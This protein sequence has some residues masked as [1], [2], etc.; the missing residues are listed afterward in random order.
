[1]AVRELTDAADLDRVQVL[2][3]SSG[4]VRMPAGTMIRNAA[5]QQFASSY[6][7]TELL[8]S[9]WAPDE[10]QTFTIRFTPDAPGTY[11]VE[12]KLT[13]QI[14][15]F[16]VS[17]APQSGPLDQ[18]GFNVRQLTITVQEPPQPNVVVTVSPAEALLAPGETFP[19][20]ATVRNR[21]GQIVQGAM[22]D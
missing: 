19:L 13:L 14:A 8:H 21:G 2:A 16:Q 9:G 7:L 10:S 15:G 18:Q 22:V 1:L 11:V 17:A 4:V 3:P 5:G 12:G 20:S 6:L